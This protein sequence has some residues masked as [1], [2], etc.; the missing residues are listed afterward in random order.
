MFCTVCG[1]LRDRCWQQ[2]VW[3][4]LDADIGG[5]PCAVTTS[6]IDVYIAQLY[7]CNIV[8]SDRRYM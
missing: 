6:I 2:Y 1:S 3:L 5:A 7:T 4:K 8:G